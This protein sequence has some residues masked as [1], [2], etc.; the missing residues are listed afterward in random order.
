VGEPTP[1]PVI[2]VSLTY[3]HSPEALI[4]EVDTYGGLIPP[5]MSRHVADL[6]IYGDGL[7]V[8]A[9][10]GEP[11]SRGLDRRVMTGYLTEEELDEIVG[12]IAGQGFFQLEDRYMPSPAPTDLP[13]RHITVNLL[14]T[15]KTVTIYPFDFADAPTAFWDVYDE[16]MRVSPSDAEVFTA[17][18]GTMTA[19]EL[20]P[21]DDLP[22]GQRNQVAPWDTPLV[23]IALPEATEG[24]HLEGERYQAVE[25]FLLRYPPHQ[26]FGSQ[27]G[28]AYQ[29]RLEAHLP[30]EDTHQ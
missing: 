15:S 14:D 18:S 19:I 16:L 13:S 3:D 12:F 29:V 9:E 20:G 10:E 25:E 23:G 27:E 28:E 24:V 4:I 1:S 7:V 8:R 21:I 26:L 30:W 5:P 22:P 11:S 6:R 17:T 2:P